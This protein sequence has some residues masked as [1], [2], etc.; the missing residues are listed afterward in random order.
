MRTGQNV[1]GL[2]VLGIENHYSPTYERCFVLVHYLNPDVRKAPAVYSD[3]PTFYSELWDA[4]EEKML[5][6]CSD[7]PTPNLNLMCTIQDKEHFMDCNACR[8][9]IKD[10]MTK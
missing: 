5:S 10:R 3:L 8:S 9:F 1:G 4:F 6:V 2:L 7:A